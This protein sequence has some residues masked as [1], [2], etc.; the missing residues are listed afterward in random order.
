VNA[1]RYGLQAGVFTRDIARL[2]RAWDRLDVGGVMGNEVPSWRVDRMP[3]GGTKASGVGREGVRF[4]IDEMTE[5]RLLTLS[6]E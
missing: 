4:A 6:I 1:S 5:L 2:M 3:Y